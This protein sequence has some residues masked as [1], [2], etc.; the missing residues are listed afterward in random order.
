M[1]TVAPTAETLPLL[2]SRTAIVWLTI[3]VLTI[4][5][6]C[7][8]HE[9]S[10][11]PEHYRHGRE[12]AEKAAEGDRRGAWP[13]LAIGLLAHCCCSP[14]RMAAGMPVASGVVAAWLFG[15]VRD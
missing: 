11:D 6:C 8:E 9:T 5:Y 1:L 13:F 2:P 12:L 3:A 15:L 14:R 7:I 10:F 4:A